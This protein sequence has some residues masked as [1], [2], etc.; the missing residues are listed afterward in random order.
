[1]VL[2]LEGGRKRYSIRSVFTTLEQFVLDL[3]REFSAQMLK[4]QSATMRVPAH[5]T[6]AESARIQNQRRVDLAVAEMQKERPDRHTPL[7]REVPYPGLTRQKCDLCFG[8]APAWEWCIEVKM[9]R[10][11]GDSYCARQASKASACT[12]CATRTR[13]SC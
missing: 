4:A 9:L 6:S 3:R 2:L 11:M 7:A 5:H 8:T 10:L 1:M 13:A 12:A